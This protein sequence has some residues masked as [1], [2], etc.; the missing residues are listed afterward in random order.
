MSSGILVDYFGNGQFTDPFHPKLKVTNLFGFIDLPDITITYNDVTYDYPFT[1]PYP[2]KNPFLRAV[3]IPLVDCYF[4]PVNEDTGE[5]VMRMCGRVVQQIYAGQT[6]WREVYTRPCT[7]QNNQQS[8]IMYG[9]FR[10]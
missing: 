2:I 5:W 8:K 4:I 9:G 1:L 6:T 7:N 10:G 3:N